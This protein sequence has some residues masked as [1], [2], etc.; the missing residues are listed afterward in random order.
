MLLRIG[1]RERSFADAVQPVQRRDGDMALVA[2]ERRL[3]L[4]ERVVAPP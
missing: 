2:L 3:D 1:R 4:C